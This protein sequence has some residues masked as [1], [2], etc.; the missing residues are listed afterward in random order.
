MSKIWQGTHSRMVTVTILNIC[1]HW[2]FISKILNATL[3]NILSSQ[4]QLVQRN[5]ECLFSVHEREKCDNFAAIPGRFE[6]FVSEGQQKSCIKLAASKKPRPTEKTIL[7]KSVETRCQTSSFHN[8]T[9]RTAKHKS[10][11]IFTFL[12]FK[13]SKVEAYCIPCRS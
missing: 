13:W 9:W 3:P 7:R 10:G 8:L 1:I 4:R 11:S 2:K 5:M 6:I 12:K